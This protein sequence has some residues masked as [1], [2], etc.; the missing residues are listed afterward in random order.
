MSQVIQNTLY[1]LT[2]G[3]Y[4]HRDHL[5]LRIEQDGQPQKLPYLFTE[6]IV[7]KRYIKNKTPTTICTRLALISN[8][9]EISTLSIH[10]NSATKTSRINSAC[11]LKS[12]TSAV[13]GK[14]KSGIKNIAA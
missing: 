7:A 2:P 14:K 4:V 11:L 6:K 8:F 9:P 3:L 5:A 10:A 1:L 13:H 12:K